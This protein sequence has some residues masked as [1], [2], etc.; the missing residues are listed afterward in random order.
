MAY[1][2]IYLD[3]SINTKIETSVVSLLYEPFYVGKGTGDRCKWIKESIPEDL[4][5]LM[6][7]K[8]F[9]ILSKNIDL[10]YILIDCLTEDEA[11]NLEEILTHEIGLIIE[12][13]GPLRNLRHG[14][15]GG[16][17]L[18]EDTKQKLSNLNKGMN[19]PNYGIP[20]TKERKEKFLS[21]YKNSIDSG[22][23]SFDKERMKNTWAHLKR[24]YKVTFPDGTISI[25]ENL[26]KWCKESG[27]SLTVLRA[28]LKNGGTVISAYSQGKRGSGFKPSKHEGLKIEYV[29]T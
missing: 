28:A 26:T 23:V 20:W 12:K 27:Y 8:V 13:N 9:Q 22:K 25:I 4:N 19:N 17:V 16:Y 10:E 3:T 24:T 18:S 21:T 1:V 29:K 15:I 2:Y 6:H 11:F 5:K 7:K 14:G